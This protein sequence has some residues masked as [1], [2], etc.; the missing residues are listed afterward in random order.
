MELMKR[1]PANV[2]RRMF[3][4]PFGGFTGDLF[5]MSPFALLRAMTDEM[6]KAFTS[7]VPFGP[8]EKVWMPVVEMREKDGNLLINAELPGINEKDV[9]IE[10]ADDTLTIEGERKEEHEETKSGVHKTER[11]YG[12]F[13]RAIRLPEGAEVEKAKAEFRNGVLEVKMPVVEPKLNKRTIPIEG[14][15]PNADEKPKLEKEKVAAAR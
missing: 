5:R 10:V 13:Y 2:A 11:S 7:K 15:V 6:D 9:K 1:T 12:H 14:A 4:D 8:E 3:F